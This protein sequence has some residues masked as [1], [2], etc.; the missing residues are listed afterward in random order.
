[1]PGAVEKVGEQNGTAHGQH[2]AGI[3]RALIRARNDKMPPAVVKTII[4]ARL[5]CEQVS[6]GL[7]HHRHRRGRP[8]RRRDH[9]PVRRGRVRRLRRARFWGAPRSR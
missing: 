2:E 5:N 3:L 6:S 8:G 9:R 4:R 7:V 1:M